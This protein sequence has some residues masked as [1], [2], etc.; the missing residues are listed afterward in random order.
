[1]KRIIIFSI[2]F[3]LLVL[4]QVS[5]AR[6]DIQGYRNGYRSYPR[7]SRPSPGDRQFGENYGW[8]Y[9]RGEGYWYHPVSMWRWRPNNGWRQYPQRNNNNHNY[10]NNYYYR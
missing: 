6:N 4:Q 9:H 3:V 2:I 5:C 10:N 8:M 1:M 7:P